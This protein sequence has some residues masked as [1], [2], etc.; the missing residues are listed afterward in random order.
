MPQRSTV[1]Y[2]MIASLILAGCQ[3]STAPQ[4][5]A[6]FSSNRAAVQYTADYNGLYTLY[7]DD[8]DVSAGPI[9]TTAHLNKGE[10]IG[11][12]FDGQHIP[13]AIAGKQRT[14]LTPG[15]YRWEMTPDAGQID[16]DKTNSTA[17][18]VVLIGAA[19]GASV[20][21]AIVAARHA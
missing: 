20:A 10:T 12:D 14:E 3:V 5:V 1:V 13:Y 11:F 17:V 15:R 4:D 6:N 9:V 21:I 8:S 7:R 2:V 18:V 16:W 19:I